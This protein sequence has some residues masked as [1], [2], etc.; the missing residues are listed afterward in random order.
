MRLLKFLSGFI[1]LLVLPLV[2]FEWLIR[3]L[4]H[5]V[6]KTFEFPLKCYDQDKWL[7]EVDMNKPYSEGG[8]K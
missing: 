3:I 7:W 6:N 2:I 1:A 5:I 4:W 8:N